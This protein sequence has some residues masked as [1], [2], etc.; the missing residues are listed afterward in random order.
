MERGAGASA[1][2]PDEDYAAAGATLCEPAALLEGV[3]AVV[4]VARPSAEEVAAMA[5]GTV[6]IGFLAP[7]TDTEGIARLEQRGIVGFAME[8]VPR[9][10][11]A[12]SMDALSSQATVAG[13]KAVLIAADRVPEALPAC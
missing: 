13:Y 8:S 1:G 5:P 4:R 2:F 10:T 7:L 6:L 3:D 9:I 12:Q 11:R